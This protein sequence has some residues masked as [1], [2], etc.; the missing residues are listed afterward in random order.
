MDLVRRVV[1]TAKVDVFGNRFVG[2]NDS[3]VARLCDECGVVEVLVGGRHGRGRRRDWLVGWIAT[4]NI[5]RDILMAIAL[6]LITGYDSRAPYRGQAADG[7]P[8]QGRHTSA[9][10][11]RLPAR[12]P[13]PRAFQGAER[14]DRT[15]DLPLRSIDFGK[16]SRR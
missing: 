3:K 16:L 10:H 1:S 12:L 2:I 14:R 5:N 8:H 11:P 7:H 6:A 4:G 15:R 9:G 13:L